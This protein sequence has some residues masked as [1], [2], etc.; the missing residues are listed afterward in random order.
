MTP[1]RTIGLQALSILVCGTAFAQ[2][3]RPAVETI[4]GDPF[5][6]MEQFARCSARFEIAAEIARNASMPAGA[7]EY[8]G[9]SR[10][11][12]VAANFFAII[13]ATRTGSED[14]DVVAGATDRRME[15]AENFYQ[16]ELNSQRA[17]SERGEM[18]E[19]GFMYCFELQPLQIRTIEIMRREGLL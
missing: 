19:A 18:D 14:A 3:P 7:E 6:A 11:A 16:L 17:T 13:L 15:Q 10:G 5:A 8:M 12:R 2:S 4:Q 1:L 9:A